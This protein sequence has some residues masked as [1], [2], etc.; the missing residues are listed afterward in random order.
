M[1]KEELT[2]AIRKKTG[3]VPFYVEG[4]VRVRVKH[5]EATPD[6]TMTGFANLMPGAGEEDILEELYACE[7]LTDNSIAYEVLG[8]IDE[9][10]AVVVNMDTN[11]PAFY[12][13][14]DV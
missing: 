5:T 2:E 7:M 12:L 14:V 1:T 4:A 9:H 8:C 10:G 6:G 11:E 13:T 3:R